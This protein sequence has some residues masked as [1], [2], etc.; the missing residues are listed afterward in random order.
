VRLLLQSFV[1]GADAH[2]IF[3]CPLCLLLLCTLL[4]QVSVAYEGPMQLDPVQLLQLLHHQR[5]I[6]K[7]INWSSKV[8]SS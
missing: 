2:W 7:Y 1:S 8:R 6:D 4:L 3:S 5:Q